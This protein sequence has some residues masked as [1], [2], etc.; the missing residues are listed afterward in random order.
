MSS[1]A[2]LPY[3]SPRIAT[4]PSGYRSY[5]YP[6]DDAGWWNGHCKSDGQLLTFGPSP[7]HLR[8]FPIMLLILLYAGIVVSTHWGHSRMSSWSGWIRPVILLLVPIA[9][10]GGMAWVVGK[11]NRDSWITV[12]GAKKLIHL[13]IQRCTL[14]F[15]EVIRL[16]LVSFGPVGHLRAKSSS[17]ELQI[18]FR[19]EHGEQIRCIVNQPEPGAMK[20]FAIAFQASTGIPVSRVHSTISGEWHV[21]P[22]GAHATDA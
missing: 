10:A 8:M 12:D 2:P 5:R 6:A 1:P 17:G 15:A 9:F 20:R 14:P 11:S 16:Q 7:T 22:F 13:P 4:G 18:V 19:D 21:E 3:A